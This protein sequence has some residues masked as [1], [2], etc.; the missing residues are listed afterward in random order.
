MLK[1]GFEPGTTEWSE[2]VY[3]IPNLK[4]ISEAIIHYITPVGLNNFQFG[5]TNNNFFFIKKY[6]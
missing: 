5:N 4:Y 1:T 2:G 6:Y 3:Y